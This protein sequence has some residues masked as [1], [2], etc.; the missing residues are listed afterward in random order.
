MLRQ[1]I[2]RNVFDYTCTKSANR[3]ALEVIAIQFLRKQSPEGVTAA[4]LP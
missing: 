2:D 3:S 4:W 1:A